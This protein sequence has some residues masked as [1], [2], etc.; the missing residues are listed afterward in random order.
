MSPVQSNR[1]GS[2]RSG[3]KNEPNFKPTPSPIP[4]KFVENQSY[5]PKPEK[6]IKSSLNE[7]SM[8]DENDM[9]L[10]LEKAN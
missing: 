5:Q 7:P 1:S 4:K 8:S 6:I 3:N 2:F 9:S 10:D